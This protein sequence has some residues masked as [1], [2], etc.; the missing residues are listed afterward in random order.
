MPDEANMD[1]TMRCY[2]NEVFKIAKEKLVE[3]ANSTASMFGC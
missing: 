1:G 2:S 3:I